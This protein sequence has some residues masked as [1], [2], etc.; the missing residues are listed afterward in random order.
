MKHSNLAAQSS[1]P[2]SRLSAAAI[3]SLIKARRLRDRRLGQHLF[4]D[5][6]WDILLEALEADLSDQKVS[7]TSLCAASAVPATTALRWIQKLE[8][9]GLLQRYQDPEDMR[10]SWISLT[11]TGSAKLRSYFGELRED[12]FPI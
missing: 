12:V 2:E 8:Q 10:R 7:I 4:A 11:S 9:D 3:R 1:R 6:A 5:P